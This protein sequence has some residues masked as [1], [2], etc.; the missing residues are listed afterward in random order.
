VH[1]DQSLVGDPLF[2][3]K[4]ALKVTPFRTKRFRSISAHS[5]STVRAG[6]KTFKL[7]LIGSRP[8][9]F[10]R[11]IDEPRTFTPKSPKGGTKRNFVSFVSKIQLPSKEVCYYVS[12][13]ENVQ[14]QGY[15]YI[16]PLSNDP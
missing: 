8:R 13:C 6:E 12:S 11:A 3:L 15:S 14:R 7:A 10:Q 1:V 16:I 9:A 4:F 5:V 2:T